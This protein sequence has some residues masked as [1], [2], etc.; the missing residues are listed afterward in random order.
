MA[1]NRHGIELGVMVGLANTVIFLHFM[2]PV[3]D[4]RAADAFNQ[5]VESSERTALMATTALTLLVAG[6]ARSIETFMIA[7]AV[8][9]GVDFAFKHANAVNPSTNKVMSNSSGGIGGGDNVHPLPDYSAQQSD[10][11]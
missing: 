10:A 9:V 4:V 2:P 7:G 6:F 5:Q 11:G 1:V 8:V 3:T